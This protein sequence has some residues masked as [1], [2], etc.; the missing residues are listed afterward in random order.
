MKHLHSLA[1]GIKI[2][3]FYTLS[4]SIRTKNHADS[5][6]GWYTTI[7]H[8]EI[9]RMNLDMKFLHGMLC[10]YQHYWNCID[11]PDLRNAIASLS[12]VDA[13]WAKQ[14]AKL[15]EMQLDERS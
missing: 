7:E 12:A 3:K 9:G 2:A 1:D 14:L 4:N 8:E 15:C 10:T 6:K 13:L 11:K 5:K